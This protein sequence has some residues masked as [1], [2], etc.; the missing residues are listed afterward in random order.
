MVTVHIFGRTDVGKLRST[1]QDHM[2]I[3]NLD[4]DEVAELTEPDSFEVAPRGPLLVVCDGMGGAAGGEVASKLA[5]EVLWAEMRAA[6]QTDERPV[7]A[8]LMRRAVRVA[9][10][11]V[12]E[13][14]S[15]APKLRGM[16]TTLSAA[17]VVGDA[18]ILA[19]VGDSRAYIHRGATLTQVTRDQ[20][21]VSAL[22]HA[23]RMT[24]SE[25]RSSG[26]SSVIL[27]ALG[28]EPDVEVSLSIVELRAGDRLLLCSDGL[29]GVV[30]D[31]KLRAAMVS[32]GELGEAVRTLISLARNAG[33]PD[34]ITA[35]VA[36]FDGDG[37]K[38]PRNPEDLPRFVEIDPM[39]EGDRAMSTTSKVARRLAARA[40]IGDD[41]GPPVVPVT[42]QFVAL[43]GDTAGASGARTR[44]KRARSGESGPAYDALRERSRLGLTGWLVVILAVLA[45]VAVGL[46]GLS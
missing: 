26:Q 3:G 44:R 35:L 33:G 29:H 4:D 42:G 34:N 21:I 14:A 10:R 6:Q 18:L 32:C 43:G 7:F 5:A 25:A 1:N 24:R 12:F 11:R 30:D 41:P 17:G 27:Q 46:W 22:M 40:G 19:Q 37:L 31:T 36:E 38:P 15:A 45:A 39:E 16:G 20:S 13:E 23:G 28:C 8:R 2:L 9:N